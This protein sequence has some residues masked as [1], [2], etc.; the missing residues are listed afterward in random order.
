MY[1]L[2]DSL[3]SLSVTVTGVTILTGWKAAPSVCVSTAVFCATTV[4]S[5]SSGD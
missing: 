4:R 1:G 5:C 3:T 2:L